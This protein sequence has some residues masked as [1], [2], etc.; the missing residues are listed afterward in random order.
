MDV[1]V[2][3]RQRLEASPL[4]ND[5]SPLYD[6]GYAVGLASEEETTEEQ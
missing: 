5:C 2:R 6:R 4:N 3:K 1:Y